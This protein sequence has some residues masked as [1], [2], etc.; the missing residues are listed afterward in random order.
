M[1]MAFGIAALL[2]TIGVIVWIMGSITL[3]QTKQALD[4]QKKVQPQ[5]QQMAGRGADG[6]VASESIKL[7]PDSTGGRVTSFIV[8]SIEPTGP[9]ATF[10][11]LQRGDSI[12]EIGPQS[13]RDIGEVGAAKDFLTDAYQR[14]LQ[15]VVVRQD[16]RITL[17]AADTPAPAPGAA[18]AGSALDQQLQGITA[19]R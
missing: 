18:P 2:V 16:K 6:R 19:P 17:P 11:G 7:Q 12:V 1:R 4:V 15:I 8:T 9:L 5:V 14:Q 3:P 10:Y 13:A